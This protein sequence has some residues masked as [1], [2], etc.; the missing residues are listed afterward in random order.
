MSDV[1]SFR[2]QMR[3]DEGVKIGVKKMK[4]SKSSGGGDGCAKC[5]N[6]K[7]VAGGSTKDG[8]F[9]SASGGKTMLSSFGGKG[10]KKGK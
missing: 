8:K 6:N 4:V 2:E 10:G 1:V 7:V 5:D 9:V 3:Y